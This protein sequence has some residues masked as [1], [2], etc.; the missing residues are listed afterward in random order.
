MKS[1]HFN[2]LLVGSATVLSLVAL[3][4]YINTRYVF[5]N[6]KIDGIEFIIDRY[7]DTLPIPLVYITDST[8]TE[9]QFRNAYFCE[10]I[11]DSVLLVKFKRNVKAREFRLYFPAAVEQLKVRGV[12]LLSGSVLYK[13]N[14]DDFKFNDVRL[15]SKTS[16][17]LIVASDESNG[18]LESRRFYY[19]SDLNLFSFSI[20]V[21]VLI[22]NLIAFI[23]YRLGYFGLMRKLS[24]HEWSVVLLIS[25]LF[26]SQKFFNLSLVIS[27]LLCLR[28][29]KFGEFLNDKINLLFYLYFMVLITSFIFWSPGEINFK[30]FEKNL[31]FLALPIYFSMIPKSNFLIYFPFF[32]MIVGLFFLG[33]SLVDISI[34]HNLEIASFEKFASDPI[35]L[36]YVIA[37]SLICVNFI[38]ERSIYKHLVQI[39]LFLFLVLCGSKMI[40]LVI[41]IAFLVR[42]RRSLTNT[43]IVVC[44]GV[45]IS[46]FPPVQHRFQSIIKMKDLGIVTEKFV[47]DHDDPR[48]N[49]ITL[50]L[51][52]WQESIK[53]L[54]TFS[55][56]VLGRGVSG[57][58]QEELKKRMGTRGIYQHAEFNSHNQYIST[59]YMVGLAGILVLLSILFYIYRWA[60]FNE[61]AIV[62]HVLLLMGFAMLSESLLQ[63]SMGITIFCTLVL[64]SMNSDRIPQGVT[65]RN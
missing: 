11:N 53:S 25:S 2:Y 21:F 49:G 38:F 43:F 3:A 48:L 23:I 37:F 9:V 56:V 24:F 57:E 13:L 46:F 19:S 6:N 5:L 40:L 31:L 30:F 29:F 47:N 27:A 41:A 55:Y 60:R 50:R 1:K 61:N 54:D 65:H 51:I 17:E 4:V 26:L 44:L 58:A 15:L 28:N 7:P 14:L 34:F 42:S 52:L 39:C 45:L 64:L 62:Y 22:A 59:L 18:Y 32:A 12:S 16:Q 35:Y 20:L 63:R 33:T 8:E 36:S 10:T